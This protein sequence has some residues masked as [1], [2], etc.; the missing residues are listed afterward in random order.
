MNA[1]TDEFSIRPPDGS[2]RSLATC[3]DAS[4]LVVTETSL[5][6][7]LTTITTSKTNSY[8]RPTTNFT[9]VSET[10]PM[11]DHLWLKC[12]VKDMCCK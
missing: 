3:V 11:A 2:P 9:R 8:Y 6:T 4:E 5:S 10:V 12:D 7:N 1:P